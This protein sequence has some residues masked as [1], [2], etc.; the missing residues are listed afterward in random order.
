MSRYPLDDPLNQKGS[1][2]YPSAHPGELE[3]ILLWELY[4]VMFASAYSGSSALAV[5]I[6]MAVA[7]F[8][9]HVAVYVTVTL[10]LG[11]AFLT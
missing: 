1:K 9:R 10:R 2:D 6:H 7:G 3:P 4:I 8:S 5:V 11:M